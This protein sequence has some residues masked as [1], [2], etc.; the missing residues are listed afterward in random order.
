MLAQTDA[1][2]GVAWISGKRARDA[3]ALPSSMALAATWDLKIAY[4]GS[5]AIAQ[6]ARANGM[7]A[8]LAGGVTLT[9]EP[10]NGRNFEYLGEDPLLAGMLAGESIRGI[11]DQHVLSTVKH[12]ALNAQETL[13]NTIPV[14]I[15][16]AAARESDLLA[17]EIAIERGAPGSVM[18]AY[19][20]YNGPFSCGSDYLLN[21]VLKQDWKY[22]GYVMSDWGAT[23]ATTDAIN[24]LADLERQIHGIPSRKTVTVT[25][26]YKQKGT[27][28]GGGTS[29]N[30]FYAKGGIRHAATGLVI[31]PSNPGT[32]LAAEPQTGGEVLTP[33]KGI[34]KQRAMQL[35]GVVGS[36]YGFDVVPRGGARTPVYGGAGGGGRSG[37]G[38]RPVVLQVNASGA[39][40]LESL[41]LSWLVNAV[42][43]G[44]VPLQL[45]QQSG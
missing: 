36:A 17:F 3:T 22:P 27:T 15:S 34:S 9:R 37:G 29:Y 45:T 6:D 20:H 12:Y 42:R 7:N 39:S 28:P 11:Q 21:K 32:V 41:F 23:H 44:L 18:C 10:R 33:L 14:T 35:T 16:D 40:G 25:T 38:S 43:G 8:L 13:Q 26:V 30:K 19:N 31:P 4:A 5:A 1:S 24:G 2:L